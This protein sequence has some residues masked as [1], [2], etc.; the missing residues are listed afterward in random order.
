ML[1][2]GQGD[3]GWWWGVQSG[4][5]VGDMGPQVCTRTAEGSIKEETGEEFTQD[6]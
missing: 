4:R 5:E 2:L 3:P 6:L 1:G